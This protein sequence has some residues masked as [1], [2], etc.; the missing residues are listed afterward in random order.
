MIATSSRAVAAVSARRPVSPNRGRRRVGTGMLEGSRFVVVIVKPGCTEARNVERQV[1]IFAITVLPCATIAL[2]SGG[3]PRGG[4]NA[5][6]VG[7]EGE[8][9]KAFSWL[10]L[11]EGCGVVALV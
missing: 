8:G 2:G 11:G 5:R 10:V 3:E 6:P 7:P 9:R 1:V 4:P